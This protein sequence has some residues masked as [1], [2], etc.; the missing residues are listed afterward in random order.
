MYAAEV[1]AVAGFAW[2]KAFI[3]CYES[4]SE[5]SNPELAPG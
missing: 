2:K 3:R 5:A 4:F 1:I